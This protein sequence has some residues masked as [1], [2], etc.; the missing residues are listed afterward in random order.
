MKQPLCIHSYI[1]RVKGGKRAQL[2]NGTRE[3]VWVSYDLTW[4]G[5]AGLK[6]LSTISLDRGLKA[7]VPGCVQLR[8]APCFKLLS[9]SHHMQDQIAESMVKVVRLIQ[10]V[11]VTSASSDLHCAEALHSSPD[12]ESS[13]HY[14]KIWN[15]DPDHIQSLEGW[16]HQLTKLL[17]IFWGAEWKFCNKTCDRCRHSCSKLYICIAVRQK[18]R[19][20]TSHMTCEGALLPIIRK[21]ISSLFFPSI[22]SALFFSSFL[23]PC[24]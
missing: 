14:K 23:E 6:R 22:S 24:L 15:R 8:C 3:I 4:S 10:T 17:R 5:K 16:P 12:S 2:R 11:A 21:L 19:W 9:G 18:C 13:C 1:L 7:H 20:S